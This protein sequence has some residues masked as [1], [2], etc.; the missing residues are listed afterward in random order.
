MTMRARISTV[1]V[2]MALAAPVAAQGPFR[3]EVVVTAAATPVPF[4]SVTRTLTI[5][6]REQ[7][8]QL[9]VRSVAD[10]LRLTGSVDVRM[11]GERGGQT[12]FAVR[13]AN[14]GQ[15]LV[16]VDGVR[17]NDAQSGHHNGDI[18]VPLD[19][20]ERIEVL[21][22]V[23]SSLFGA[24]AF[25]GTINVITR[26]DFRGA[27]GSLET[28]SFGLVAGR[29]QVGAAR[30]RVHQT[31]AVSVDRSSGFMFERDYLM[32]GVSSRTALADRSA[33]AVSYLWKDFG[34]NG[35][36][37]NAPSHEWTNQTLV[38]ADHR[39]GSWAGW[40][41]GGT[42]SYRTHGD[43]FI[44]NV[45]G[46]APANQHRTHATIASLRASRTMS[47]GTSVTAGVEGG[48]DW[49]RS[50]NL[51]NHTTR[52]VS[53][54]GEWRQALGQT[55]Q[56]DASVRVDRYTEFG[57]AVS[58]SLGVGWW[59]SS[60]VRLRASAGR[61]F[62]VPTFT[63]R[64]YSDPANLARPEVHAEAAWA[65]EGGADVF[66]T[67]GWTLGATVFGR[68]D[69]DVIDWLRAT[70]A[71]RWRTYNIRDVDT[72]GVEL[73]A[74]RTLSNGTFL[75]VAYTGL[76]VQAA[77]VTLLSKYVLDYAPHALSAGAVV[78]L[79]ASLRLAPRIELKRRTRST[80][81]TDYAVLDLRASRR[82]GA[83]EIRVDG[84][85][86]GDASYQEVLGVA[87]PGRAV[88]VS[89]ALGVR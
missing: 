31:L 75:Q 8:A 83:Y 48:A 76:D 44:F 19:M 85:N 26:K 66:L 1:A 60:V 71:D 87:M 25:G 67:N 7:I 18:P 69:H 14:F 30:G 63:E 27:S 59:P 78:P 61:A 79:P 20:V 17:L 2:L 77:G 64:Y 42:A 73:S 58:P 65:G 62:R 82:F 29:G 86:L 5:I 4:G 88:S 34:A 32:T 22:G 23:G 12:D 56:L 50:N 81:T 45:R 80:G 74:G 55:T 40:Q 11:R 16:L 36:Y 47:G 89:L 84:T 43:R 28:G 10:V 21:H 38:A 35:F 53:G 54:F 9:P 57:T 52:R 33:V 6:T 46:T 49:I 51:G 13:G 39:F 24:D 70:T 3:Q 72:I 41:V 37:G 68:L 15:M